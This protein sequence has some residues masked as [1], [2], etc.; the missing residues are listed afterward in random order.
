MLAVT[1]DASAEQGVAS[2]ISQT[3]FKRACFISVQ[4]V[5]ATFVDPGSDFGRKDC[6]GCCQHDCTEDRL[7]C[8]NLRHICLV[9]GSR[10]YSGCQGCAGNSQ[11][12]RSDGLKKASRAFCTTAGVFPC[13]VLGPK[14]FSDLLSQRVLQSFGPKGLINLWRKTRFPDLFAD[15]TRLYR[16]ILPYRFSICFRRRKLRSFPIISQKPQG[17]PGISKHGCSDLLSKSDYF[18]FTLIPLLKTGSP[19]VLAQTKEG[20]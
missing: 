5:S 14:R 13:L 20:C 3:V 16:S 19:D 12:D 6:A 7:V 18:I 2:K 1:L 8:V 9:A 11:H 10:I 15:S 4:E 17:L